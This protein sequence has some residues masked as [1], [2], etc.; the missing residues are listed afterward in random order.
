[1]NPFYFDLAKLS[2]ALLA[3]VIAMYA[4]HTAKQNKDRLESLEDMLTPKQP[5]GE[6]WRDQITG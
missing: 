3:L 2:V 6:S 1:M 5:E 4:A